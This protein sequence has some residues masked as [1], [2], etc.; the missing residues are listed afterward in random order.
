[1]TT[2]GPIPDAWAS[3]EDV[4]SGRVS[5][6]ELVAAALERIEASDDA[7]NAF[8]VVLGDSAR[9]EAEAADELCRR[10]LAGADA[11][12]L[13]PLLGVPVSIKDHIWLAGQPATN[14]S[15]ALADFVPDVDA[16]PVARLKA[17]GAIVVG[18]T[19]NPEFCYR[20]FT[21]NAVFGLTRNPWDLSRT[22]GGS[23]GG[24]GASV[25]Y[26]ATPIA[27]GTDG[28][29]SIRIPAAFCGVVGHKPTF[30]LVP[31]L[32]GFRGWPS[33]S[34]DGPLTRTVR[35]AALALTVM[36]GAAAEDDLSFPVPVGDLRRAVTE[37][38]DW[39][40]VRVAVSED[41]GWAPV[42]QSVRSVFRAAVDRLE[43]DG[44]RVEQAQ[45]A[46]PY[47]TELWNAL[48]VPEGFASE[49]PLLERSPDLIEPET[50]EIIEAGRRATARDYLDAL[51]HRR[52]YRLAWD[53]F[54]EEYDVLL[55]PSMPLP[56]FGTDVTTPGTIDGVP[57][58]PFFDDWCA[59]AL[60]ANL[61]G[62]PAC[63]VP[64]GLDDAGLPL[65]MQV[66]GRRWEDALVLQVA[67]A[68]E[69]IAPWTGRGPASTRQEGTQ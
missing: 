13:P 50:R 54:F 43:Q 62:Q 16:V 28:G 60:P 61:T 38:V 48:A 46:A 36:A 49:G 7:V 58:D 65:G 53:A 18:K 19:N 51:E 6:A 12:R 52:E 10:T 11:R 14:G 47:P 39:A 66:L 17:A 69:R 29:G 25:A 3:A 37:P 45:P 67:A 2:P 1:M 40:S 26:G 30:G 41:L 9:A 55:T 24:A 64:I 20:G 34:V 4:R 31:K 63:A 68:W 42:E 59:L 32:P 23:S 44:A 27:L 33:L 8:T 15:R 5:C 57:V 35:D 21:D 22:P 56:A